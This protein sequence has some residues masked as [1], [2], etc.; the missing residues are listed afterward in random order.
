MRYL[1]VRTWSGISVAFTAFARLK[2]RAV[3]LFL[4]ALLAFG[5]IYPPASVYA[6]THS[7]GPTATNIEAKNPHKTST[8]PSIG[9]I[10]TGQAPAPSTALKSAIPA[11]ADARPAGAGATLLGALSG[12]GDNEPLANP[13][14]P[15]STVQP[16]ELTGKRTA[17]SSVF[18]N[19]NGSFTK[20]NYF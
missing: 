15:N 3:A 11:A 7:T 2:Q 5:V 14:V 19:K 8:T 9:K 4:V 17:T 12:K 18:Q 13:T 16:H 20:T 1:T 10:N 6:A